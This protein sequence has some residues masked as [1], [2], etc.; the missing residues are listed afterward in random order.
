[1]DG[2][3]YRHYDLNY[4]SSDVIE[5]RNYLTL[6]TD[7]SGRKAR[8]YSHDFTQCW[9]YGGDSA[10]NAIGKLVGTRYFD[11]Q[12]AKNC[13]AADFN[14]GSAIAYDTAGRPF[15]TTEMLRGLMNPLDGEYHTYTEFDSTGRVYKQRYPGVGLTIRHEYQ[16]G[17]AYK[18]VNDNDGRVYRHITAVNANGQTTGVSYANGTSEVADY[19]D[20][21]GLIKSNTLSKG[22]I[23]HDLNYTYDASSNLKTRDHTFGVLS[24]NAN[25]SETYAYDGL[26]RLTDRTVTLPSTYSMTEA[27]RFG[28]LGNFTS[29]QGNKFYQYNTNKRLTSI[30]SNAGLTGAKLYDF[31]YDNNGNVTFDGSR[32]ISY[33]SFDKPIQLTKG[34]YTATEFIY[35]MGHSRYYRHDK[36]VDN[37][38][39]VDTHTAYLGGLEKTYRQKSND[40]IDLIEY[41]MTVGNVVITERTNE[42]SNS[43]TGEAYLHKDHLGSPLTITNKIGAVIQQNVYDPWGKVHQLYLDDGGELGGHLPLTTRGYTGHEGIDGLDIIHMNGR[44]YDAN[45]GRFLQADPL[46]QAPKN[47]QSY[48]RYSYVINNPLTLTDPSGFSWLSKTWKKWG[49]M[50]VAAVAIYFT[51][52]AATGWATG[53]LTGTALAGSQ[54]AIGAIA[55]AITGAVSGA[56]MTGSL[57][58]TLKGAMSGAVFGAIGGQIHGAENAGSAMSTGEQMLAHATA[59]GVLSVVQG[60]NFGNGFVTAGIMKGIGKINT[61]DTFG[62]TMV[63]AIAGGTLSKLTGGKFANG[64]VS[65]A[66]QYVVNETAK[67]INSFYKAFGVGEAISRGSK[68]ILTDEEIGNIIFNE[69][70]SL[71]GSNI[72]EAQNLIAH[73]VINADESLGT[74]RSAIAHTAPTSM[75]TLTNKAEIAFRNSISATVQS[76]RTERGYGVD[77]TDGAIYFNFRDPIYMATYKKTILSTRFR[78]P[79]THSIG[80]F[81]NSYPTAVLGAAGIDMPLLEVSGGRYSQEAVTKKYLS[82]KNKKSTL[83]KK[84]DLDTL[85]NA[86]DKIEM[87]NC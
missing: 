26:N 49:K 25:T 44:I 11:A 75:V 67:T 50:I 40:S 53:W 83:F 19:F 60:G 76:V 79:V 24:Q 3:S 39:E 7:S 68:A 5:E 71:S 72:G 56:I 62:R 73:T 86:I 2:Y 57:K 66:M 51:A 33:S 84:L 70:R 31:E 77:P 30:Y 22:S 35:G 9:I 21:S 16:N 23:L 85:L 12:S 41:K 4:D 81:K 36:R 74:Q 13:T 27:Y 65:S 8:Q 32:N 69:T 80:P 1:L 14:Q 58:G 52:G 47:S 38:A 37:G 46:I 87:T 17:Y 59:G 20:D 29:K 43:S 82:L 15:H 61:S 18:L 6:V 55:G 34:S 54:V 64:A 45:I 10:N 42:T 48:N 78:L 28:G 63:Q